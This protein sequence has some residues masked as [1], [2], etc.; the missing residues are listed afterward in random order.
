MSR[1]ALVGNTASA[2]GGGLYNRGT[3]TIADSS[4]GGVGT[5]T[6]GYGNTSESRGGGIFN[7]GTG[8]ANLT[9]LR[10]T[11]TQNRATADG[12]GIYNEDVLTIRNSTF[13][14]N[15]AD[16]NGGA[17][18]NSESGTAQGT[19][20]IRTSTLVQNSAANVGGGVANEGPQLIDVSNTIIALNV[21]AVADNDVRGGFTSS[22]FNLIGDVGGAVG[23]VDGQNGDQIGTTVSPLNPILGPLT[24]NGGPTLTHELLPGSP[25]IDTGDNTGGP[26]NTDQRGADRPT[27]DTSDI[28]AFE[29]N[30]YVV[31]IQDLTHVEGDTGSTPFVFTVVLDRASVE[32]VTVDYVVEPDTARVGED[33]LAQEGTVIFAPGELTKTITVQVNGDTTPEPTETFNV[34]LTGAVN[35][36]IADDLAVGTIL[37]DDAAISI[38]DVAE[39]EGDVGSKTFV[40][41]VTLSAPSVETITVDYQTTDGTATVADGDY[42]GTSGTLTFAPGELQKTIAVTVFGDTTVEPNETF[43]VDLTGSRDSAGNAVPFAKNQGVG[44]IQN[45]ETAISIGDVTLQEGDTGF[46]DF[47]FNVT[48]NQPN[49][50]PITVDWTTTDGTA[51]SGSDYVAA[52]GQ[53]LF[54]PGEMVKTITVQVIGDVRF[55]PDE[56]FFVNLSNPVNAALSDQEGLGT[57]QN[58]DPAPVQWRI[59]V[60]GAGEIEVERN[61]ATYLTTNDF[62]N[63][64]ILTGDQGGPEDDEFT[65]DFVN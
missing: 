58:D 36:T 13:S 20:T 7:A 42:Q 32:T 51:N 4:V 17:I 6:I 48:L 26:D 16:G 41:T 46:T 24:D 31:S 1:S 3:A 22:G 47:V 35:A 65:V 21:A 43:F 44:T 59:F 5:G 10:T 34:R 37:N 2:Q 30:D 50:L 29:V 9:L 25:A 64:L 55:E 15:F 56:T 8:S 14:G 62:V 52:S 11:V 61:S 23:F 38:D 12:G 63:P 27:D 28:G 18:L 53:V 57:I 40:F 19:V 49:G 60:N 39:T 54:N 33:F 45:D